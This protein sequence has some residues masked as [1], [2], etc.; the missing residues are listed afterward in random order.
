MV[1]NSYGVSTPLRGIGGWR[2]AECFVV[3]CV[4][5]LTS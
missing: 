4:S 3:G 1:A 2:V 5:M